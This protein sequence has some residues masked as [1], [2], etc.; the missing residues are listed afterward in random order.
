MITRSPLLFGF[1]RARWT[2]E[3]IGQ[4]C[5]WLE[6]TTLGGL[7][8]WLDR[9]DIVW[10]HGKDHIHS[11][12]VRYDQKK[13]VMAQLIDRSV[14]A[15]DEIVLVYEDEVPIYRQPTLSFAYGVRGPE[16]PRAERSYHSNT[17][18][19]LAGV[20]NHG[21]GRVIYRR[22]SRLGVVELVKLYQDLRRVY[23]NARIIYVIQ[24]NWPVHFHPDVLVAL[25]EQEFGHW[26]QTPG[27][28]SRQPSEKA[29]REWEGLQLPIQLVP[30]PTY[31]SW[32]NPI[33]KLWRWMK[34]EI[35]H[36]HHLAHDLAVFRGELDAF[37]TQFNRPS[38]E[39]LEYV[40]LALPR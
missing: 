31:A 29:R 2:L 13:A 30:L 16:Q 8:G 18:T 3:L 12:D 19:R 23:P 40:G 7:H 36:H 39:L 24:D 14:A 27:H 34:Q 20:L 4:A 25:Q 33:E 5:P 15:P 21:T 1:H 11:P 32:L 22:S 9:L 38:P 17:K 26:H 37:L 6:V 35:V 28:W 10:K